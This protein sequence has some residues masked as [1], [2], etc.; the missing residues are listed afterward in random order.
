MKKH[1]ADLL[2]LI[3]FCIRTSPK[4]FFFNIFACVEQSLFVFFEY[5]IWIGYN[6]NAAENGAPFSQVALLTMGVFALF[7]IHQFIDSIYFQWSFERIKPTL[8]FQM[9]RQIYEK[10]CSVDLSCYDDTDFYNDFVLS[11]T[12][13]DECI[14][15]FL[16]DGRDFLFELVNVAAYFSYLLAIDRIGLLLAVLC[17]AVNYCSSQKYAM[18]EKDARLCKTPLER[19]RAY[20]HRV[21]YLQDYAKELRLHPDM[22]SQLSRDFDRCSQELN[23][24]NHKYGL[25]LWLYGFLKGYMPVYFMLYAIYLPYLLYKAMV[26]H[27]LSLSAMVILLAAV[28]RM[29]KRGGALV[30][31]LP[32]FA[33]IGAFIEK[34]RCFLAYEP[35]IISGE[36]DVKDD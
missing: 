14:E 27:T 25:K 10:A 26:A 17:G 2:W 30:G 36:K 13:T 7:L 33:Y 9:R 6:L 24:V 34:I 28:R 11:T 1:P 19:E 21:F 35:R 20:Q 12:Q 23:T 15:R 29:I 8:T 22:R 32:R 4:L 18:L 31:R 16:N 3:R 5:T